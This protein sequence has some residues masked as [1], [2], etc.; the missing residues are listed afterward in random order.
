MYFQRTINE[1]VEC[2][3]I[4]LHTG[5]R[6]R[7][8]VR[9]AAI[10]TGIV[11]KRNDIEGSPSIR[12]SVENV[13]DTTYATKIGKGDVTI[14]TIEHLMASFAG[15]GIDNAIVE[16][17][18]PEVPVMD[19]SAAPLV[20]LLKSGGVRRQRAGKR[21]LVIKKNIRVGCDKGWAELSPSKE[22][23]I[24]CD[25]D[26]NHPML[27]K[28]SFSLSFSDSAFE[29]EIS[30]ARTFGFLKDVENL[31]NQGLIKG[32]SLDNAIV[33]D[34]F[35]VVNEGGL[36]YKD[37]FV[38]H[39]MLDAI[40]D[41]SIIGMPIIGHLQLH[42]SGHRINYELASRVM[43]EPDCWKIV[44]AEVDTPESNKFSLQGLSLANLN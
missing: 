28:Q 31:R 2:V 18:G 10:N 13:V 4:G 16:L 30:R 32:G 21:F 3:G 7:L 9:P 26:F 19:G 20:F 37:E 22:F 8:K 42:R 29:R 40:G 1:A 6:I 25:V 44:E 38:R 41:I 27:K 34:D 15:L 5:N 17:D 36:R 43:A 11:F 39:K 33:I 35:R 23:T 24:S 14:S 12:A